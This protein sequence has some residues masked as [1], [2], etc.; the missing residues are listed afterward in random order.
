MA[1]DLG[2]D[3]A[4]GI[5][6]DSQAVARDNTV[7]SP[8]R[9]STPP[10][11]EDPAPSVPP[12][13][14]PGPATGPR[15]RWMFLVAV[16]LPLLGLV[17]LLARVSGDDREAESRTVLGDDTTTSTET[18]I[19]T[20]TETTTTRAPTV[21]TAPTTTPP[22][23]P[24]PPPPT[25]P[26]VASHQDILWADVA[27]PQWAA[28]DAPRAGCDGF[29]NCEPPEA[30]RN[31]WF[32]VACGQALSCELS[33]Y[34]YP[35]VVLAFDGTTYVATGTNRP[36]AYVCFGQPMPSSYELSF[37]TQAAELRDGRWVAS[38]VTG[39]LRLA[40]QETDRCRAGS[41]TY[42]FEAVRR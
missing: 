31:I 18:T 24:P 21:T 23:P 4:W 30:Y 2:I 15:R 40:A 20:S 9:G 37:Q 10:P 25:A 11:P 6:D 8:Q 28:F 38:R 7:S 19:T 32:S 34:D 39:A 36:D 13:R 12:I 26:P 22:P 29:N 16:G 35:P 3:G 14:V 33:L 42:H 17:G 5:E 1:R 41:E 27:A